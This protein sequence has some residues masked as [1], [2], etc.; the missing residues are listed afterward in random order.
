MTSSLD[1]EITQLL[2]TTRNTETLQHLVKKVWELKE[3]GINHNITWSIIEKS[4]AYQGGSRYC[5]LC[6]SEKFHILSSSNIIN[7]KS[8]LL[9]KCRH[10]QKFPLK[11]FVN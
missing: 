10:E 1:S 4:K 7:K 6:L 9:S 8:E 3:K 11:S 2:S 5:N